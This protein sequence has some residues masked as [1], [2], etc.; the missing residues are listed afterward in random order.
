MRRSALLCL[1]VPLC[2]AQARARADEAADARALVEK[3][4]QAHGSASALA[5]MQKMTRSSIGKVFLFGLE[6][7]FQ[8]EAGDR[9]PQEMRLKLISG[10]RDQ[11]QMTKSF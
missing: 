1:L 8:D 9:A 2:M 11:A 7:P 3:A 10:A 5:K 6:L 4:V